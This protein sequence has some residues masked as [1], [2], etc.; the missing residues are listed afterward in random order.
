MSFGFCVWLMKH[1][2]LPK[3][4]CFPHWWYVWRE[5]E[6]DGML[7]ENGCCCVVTVSSG[8]LILIFLPKTYGYSLATFNKKYL[9]EWDGMLQPKWM[10]DITKIGSTG[11]L[12]LIFFIQA[13]R[14]DSS[15]LNCMFHSARNNPNN[16][17][18][19]K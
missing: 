18:I 15:C 12:V 4:V 1:V 11:S 16:Y 7:Q 5:R 10:F 19:R 9:R 2:F 14:I 17:V 3:V 13:L 6:R 8:S